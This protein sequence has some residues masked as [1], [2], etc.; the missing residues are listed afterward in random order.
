MLQSAPTA[1]P[2]RGKIVK[3]DK[4]DIGARATMIEA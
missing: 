4:R 2:G 1:L 3:R